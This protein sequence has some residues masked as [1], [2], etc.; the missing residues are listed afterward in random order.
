MGQSVNVVAVGAHPDDMEL[1]CGGTLA[2]FAE[3]GA[4]VWVVTLSIG[5]LGHRDI[6]PHEL[7]EIRY[8]E[9]RAA[10]DMIGAEYLC[11][12]QPAEYIEDSR[13]ARDLLIEVLRHA[14]SDVVLTHAPVDYH[15]DHMNT[16]QAVFSATLSSP[17]PRIVTQSK[18]LTRHPMLYYCD[19][20]GGL[21][22]QP[23]QYVDISSTYETK[24]AMLRCHK[25]Q[26]DMAFWSEAPLGLLEMAEV[27]GRFRG[28]QCKAGYAEG[29]RPALA[30]PRVRAGNWLP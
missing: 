17:I 15:P 24:V 9:A 14:Q 26:L 8:E 10:A 18:P 11:L 7:R 12:D 19:A 30:W 28:L 29:F 6:E 5:E 27:V 2:K 13:E 20:M 4:R 22:S 23:T 3:D 1:L 25:T 21:E 16:S